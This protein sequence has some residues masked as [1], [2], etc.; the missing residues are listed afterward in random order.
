MSLRLEPPPDVAELKDPRFP[1]EPLRGSHRALGKSLARFGVMTQVDA[2]AGRVE[3]EF[4]HAN[5]IAFAERY[6][7]QFLSPS[8]AHNFLDGNRRSR[9]SVFFLLVMAFKNLP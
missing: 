2:V 6:D 4:M 7:F 5:R 8:V 1:C 3:D 9:R